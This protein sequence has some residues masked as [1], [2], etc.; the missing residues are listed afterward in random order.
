[1]PISKKT[2][3][4]K[5]AKKAA[6]KPSKTKISVSLPGVSTPPDKLEEYTLC[7][8]G[9]KGVGKSSL[10]THFPNPVHFMWERGRKSL[11]AA[12]IPDR[13]KKEPPLD[14]ERF[15]AYL[16]FLESKPKSQ[17]KIIDTVDVAYD[18]CLKHVC[19][20]LDIEHPGKVNDYGASWFEVKSEFSTIMN[21]FR[22]LPGGVIFISH[23]RDREFTS[24]YGAEYNQVVPTAPDACWNYLKEVCDLAFYLNYAEED[25]RYIYLRPGPDIW[26]SCPLEDYF[27]GY[28][29]V[30]MGGSPSEAYKNLVKAF[31]NKL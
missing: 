2:P 27:K 12:V 26:T 5:K 29:E 11:K 6:R 18:S 3:Q 10:C 7:I 21:R 1:M 16:E 4:A 28:E 19:K 30:A 9:A 24:A 17:T 31:N 15:L 13:S 23:S 14:W 8:H 20:K 25:Q 22:A